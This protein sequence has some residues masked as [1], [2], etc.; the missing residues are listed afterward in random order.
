MKNRDINRPTLGERIIQFIGDLMIVEGY[1]YFSS[2]EE[3]E[4]WFHEFKA[5][6]EA[7]KGLWRGRKCRQPQG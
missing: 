7:A 5:D 4:K 3:W 6:L 2:S 1:K